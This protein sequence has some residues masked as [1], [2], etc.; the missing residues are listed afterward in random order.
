VGHEAAE[1]NAR[2]IVARVPLVQSAAFVVRD[3]RVRIAVA[4]GSAEP[5]RC[6]SL[7]KPLLFWAGADAGVFA[8]RD[9]WAR[10]AAAA[11]VRSANDPTVA[12]WDACGG[13][14]LLARL[15]E[16]TRRSWTLE[17]GGARSF[18]RVLITAADAAAG[19]AALA[20]AAR[21]GG[22][23]VAAHL[24][25]WMRSVPERQ[26]FGA[27]RAAAEQLGVP[28]AAV[29]VKCG[30]FCAQDETWLRTH[31][32]TVTDTPDGCVRGSVVL[33]A[34][35][36]PAAL[37]A[38]YAEAYVDGDEVLDHHWELAAG[39]IATATGAALRLIP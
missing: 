39:S 19:Y 6:A 17:P 14:R 20:R 37:R 32:V 27:R 13:E 31:A 33:T 15:A 16:R 7:L 26:T 1:P 12:L 34:T 24:L 38:A 18:G 22:D 3:G 36:A 35:E 10:D 8:D 9:G 28:A 23:D 4:P 21:S 2:R 5:L 29:A 11:V 30:W 25:A